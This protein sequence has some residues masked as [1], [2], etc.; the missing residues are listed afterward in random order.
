MTYSISIG[1]CSLNKNKE[2]FIQYWVVHLYLLYGRMALPS[3]CSAQVLGV[4]SC[5]LFVS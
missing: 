5:D 4:S 3:F 1:Y 2:K